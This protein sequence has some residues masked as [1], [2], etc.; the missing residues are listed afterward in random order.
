MP[1]QLSLTATYNSPESSETFSSNLPSLSD[2]KNEPEVQQKTE[3]L[4][5][6]RTSLTQMQ[7]DVNAFLTA[8]MESEKSA[9]DSKASSGKKTRE[10]K[11]EEMYGEEDS[12]AD[13]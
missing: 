11:E 8:K 6:L 13:G 12:E 4:S 5:A 3:Y 10:E 7:S 2:N 9:A 1:D